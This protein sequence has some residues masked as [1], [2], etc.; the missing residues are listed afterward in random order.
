MKATSETYPTPTTWEQIERE[1]LNDPA[2]AWAVAH[3]RQGNATKE[4]ALMAVALWMSRDRWRL[5]GEV[6]AMSKYRT[7]LHEEIIEIDENGKV[8]GNPPSGPMREP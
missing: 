3:V 4:E 2:L 5:I 8:S 1:A 6:V 7:L